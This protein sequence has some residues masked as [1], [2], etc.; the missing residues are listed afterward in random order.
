[1]ESDKLLKEK[2]N[3]NSDK[4]EKT[5]S[6]D[7]LLLKRL[8]RITKILYSDRST[9][10]ITILLL[11]ISLI[12]I[13]VIS[14]TGKILSNIPSHLFSG[15]VIGGFYNSISTKDKPLFLHVL[16]TACYVII[17]TLSSSH[18]INP[19]IR[20][21]WQRYHLYSRT[22]RLVLAPHSLPSPPLK[23]LY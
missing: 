22:P 13:Y 2:A 20:A 19:R 12:N 11:I 7:L 17:G 14:L 8:I 21:S 10:L 15:T 18:H 1:M 4:P 3:S 9:V 16:Y 6:F 23:I 5:H